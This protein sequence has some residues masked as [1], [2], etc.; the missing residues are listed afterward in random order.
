MTFLVKRTIYKK[1]KNYLIKKLSE[2][3]R[4]DYR[5]INIWVDSTLYEQ[6][7]KKAEESYLKIATFTRQLLQQALKNN[8]IKN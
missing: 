8:S 6:I 5:R 1:R 7:S 2:M 3:K 4:K